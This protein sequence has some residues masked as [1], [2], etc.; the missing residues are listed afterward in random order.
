[1]YLLKPWLNSLN[2]ALCLM[3][4]S[5]LSKEDKAAE[6]GLS[7]ANMTGDTCEATIGSCKQFI[8]IRFPKN[9]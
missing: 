9:I 5:R 1:M 2:V 4:R 7:G 3:M 6:S 8:I